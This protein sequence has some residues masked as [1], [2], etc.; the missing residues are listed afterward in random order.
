M[1]NN[2]QQDYVA[3]SDV[4][5]M[6]D[7]NIIPY[8]Q[9]VEDNAEQV[10]Q[11]NV[12]SVQNDALMMIIDDMYEQ[13]AQSKTANKQNKVVNDTL[14][15]ELARYKELVGVYEKRAKFELTEREQ[16]INEQ[17]RIIISDR[18]RKETSLNAELHSVKIQLRS[19]IDHNN[20]TALYNGNEIVRTNHAPAIVHDSE[21]TLEL[22]EITRKIMIKKVK[23]PFCVEHKYKFAPP[24]YSKENYLAT[25]TPQRDL[26]PEQIFWSKEDKE[27]KRTKTSV[28]KPLSA[29]IVYPPNTPA[30]L[31]PRMAAKVDQNALDKQC[32]KIERKNL[33]IENENLIANCLLNQLFDSVKPKVLA[34]GM[35]AI[36]VKPIPHPLKNNRSAYLNYINHL[37][38]SV[39]TVREIVE[40]SRVAANPWILHCRQ[41]LSIHYHLRIVR[42][43]D[44]HLPKS[45]NERDYKAPSTPVTRKKQVTFN[46]KPGTSSS[47]TQKHE[48]HQ[49]FQHT[50]V[51]VI[52]STGVNTSTEASG[53]K[54]RSNTKKNKILPAKSENEKKVEDHPRTNKSVWTKVNRV[55]SSISSK[56]VVI[57]SNSKSVCKTC[58]N[59]PLVK[60]CYAH[61][62]AKA[63]L[64][65]K[66]K[67]S[68]LPALNKT[69]QVRHRSSTIWYQWTQAVQ[70]HMHGESFKAQELYDW[71][72]SSRTAQIGNDHFGS[73]H[74]TMGD[75]VI[76]NSVISRV[77]YVE[78]LGHNLFF[79]GQF[80]DYDLE[81]AFRK[82]SCFV[83]DM[84]GVDLLKG[85][86]STNLYI[87]SLDDMMKSS[88]V[89]LL[90]KASKTKSWLWHRRLTI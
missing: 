23:S 10:V 36:D 48:V 26:T 2:V 13:V 70:Q 59:L 5:Y 51:P 40:E 71:K 58:A 28:P 16:K 37:K 79:I 60:M 77:Y 68:D 66:S 17:M 53:S 21:D 14:T 64:E 61:K 18:N 90:Y 42:I 52:H 32:A 43:C 49:K 87:I 46:D 65:T 84:N 80:C 15:S 39:E 29:L 55:D 62:T 31:V 63:D 89:C 85:S 38:E 88:P 30:K 7:S 19:I 45:F 11:S 41:C 86:R 20:S 33:L 57:N 8:D 24:D 56:H 12:S 73:Y 82:H 27:R 72:S 76:G 81:I 75:Y 50:N 4:E 54:P 1:Q 69:K 6:S 78:G 47:N 35:Y 34:P 67:L 22:A 25:F 44:W 3:D 83:R 74:G 9:Y